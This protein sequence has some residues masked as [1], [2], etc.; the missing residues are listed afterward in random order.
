MTASLP[1]IFRELVVKI[2]QNSPNQCHDWRLED[3]GFECV[4]FIPKLSQDGFEITVEANESEVTVFSEFFAHQHFTSDGNHEEVADYAMGLVRD[5]LSPAM[6]VRV[7]EKGGKVS[8]AYFESSR[9]GKWRNDS[10][11][12]VFRFPFFR[13]KSVRYYMNE[14]LPARENAGIAKNK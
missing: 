12:A 10:S 5:L 3:K 14:R 4:L 8:R 11:T 6:R 7:I 2:I 1:T 13:K 9:D